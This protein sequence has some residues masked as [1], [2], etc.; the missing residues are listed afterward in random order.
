[1]TPLDQVWEYLVLALQLPALSAICISQP[2]SGSGR[3]AAVSIVV[4]LSLVQLSSFWLWVA[5]WAA[6]G[7]WF[8]GA[9]P[10]PAEWLGFAGA[11]FVPWVTSLLRYKSMVPGRR[12]MPALLVYCVTGAVMVVTTIVALMLGYCGV[13][14]C[15]RSPYLGVSIA[16]NGASVVNLTTSLLV[17]FSFAWGRTI[18]RPTG[19]SNRGREA[20]TAREE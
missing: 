13:A 11:A 20:S 10:L 12:S 17:V 16:M 3:D 5:S 8:Y 15:G 2:N 19:S 6:F 1:M 4:S 18:G 9:A 7:E 14:R